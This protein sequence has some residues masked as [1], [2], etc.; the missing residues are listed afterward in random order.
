VGP[1]APARSLRDRAPDDPKEVWDCDCL[2]L[3]PRGAIRLGL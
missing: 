3:P 1:E 2:A